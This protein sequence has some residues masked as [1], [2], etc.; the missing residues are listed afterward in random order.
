[1]NSFFLK[2]LNDNF[3]IVF[4]YLAVFLVL[5]ETVSAI[6]APTLTL[7]L[8]HAFAAVVNGVVLYYFQTRNY[9]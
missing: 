5:F 4:P 8:L 9:N 3:L 2:A 7:S 6:I 1:M